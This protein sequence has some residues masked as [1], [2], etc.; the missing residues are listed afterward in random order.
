M[1]PPSRRSSPDLITA[2]TEWPGRFDFHQAVRLVELLGLSRGD[3]EPVGGAAPPEREAAAF[4][5]HPSLAYPCAPIREV[6]TS[7]GADDPLVEFQ[8]TFAG[9]IGVAGVLPKHYSELAISREVER[10]STLRDFLDL[11]HQRTLALFQRVWCRYAFPFAFEQSARHR[12]ELDPFTSSILALIGLGTPALRRRQAVDDLTLA[13]NAAAYARGARPA[14]T[15][16]GLLTATFGVPFRVEQFIGEWVDVSAE[17]R[18]S[19]LR[20]DEVPDERHA[21]GAGFMLGTRVWDVQS[22]LRLVAG[23]LT[24]EEM[25]FFAEPAPGRIGVLGMTRGFLGDG[26]E[27]DLECV[28]AEGQSPGVV[29]GEIRRLGM[30]SWLESA[31]S[32]PAE[33]CASFALDTI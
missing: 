12:G 16:A 10:D 21:L 32:P 33:R 2:L 3:R 23:P 1:A 19:L 17:D 15:L 4:R 5:V 25:E 27:Y 8:V 13:F 6:A 28:L 11:F 14:G 30:D 22:K 7:S 31:P 9:L 29:L 20:A 26:L 18:S 24:F